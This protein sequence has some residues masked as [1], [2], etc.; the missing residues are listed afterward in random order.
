MIRFASPLPNNYDQIV[1]IYTRPLEDEPVKEKIHEFDLRNE[2]W[3]KDPNF[4]QWHR[5][6]NA[7]I[8]A[9]E[10]K[11]NM[12]SEDV[13]TVEQVTP[14]VEAPVVPEHVNLPTTS[15]PVVMDQPEISPVIVTTPVLE[16]PTQSQ[17]APVLTMAPMLASEPFVAKPV[18]VETLDEKQLIEA[19]PTL[20][21]PYLKQREQLLAQREAVATTIDPTQLD[22]IVDIPQEYMNAQKRK[23]EQQQAAL[24]RARSTVKITDPVKAQLNKDTLYLPP[25]NVRPVVR[26]NQASLPVNSLPE[27]KSH[28]DVEQDIPPPVFRQVE[29]MRLEEL[30]RLCAQYQL[31]NK[32]NKPELIVRLNQNNVHQVS[33]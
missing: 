24:L 17:S 18:V 25:P 9:G 5:E 22:A 21:G 28:L 26:T 6:R 30:R 14:S 27:H 7:A 4:E 16:L 32:G 8:Q 13:K 20:D 33:M 29:A 31:S 19:N 3:D 12:Q 1:N 10:Y 23:F 15:T 11:P 2:P